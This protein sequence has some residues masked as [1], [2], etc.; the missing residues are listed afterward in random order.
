MT[1]A[2]RRASQSNLSL[3]ED[4]LE[5]YRRLFVGFITRVV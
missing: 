3:S 5:E 4:S 2:Q 1:E